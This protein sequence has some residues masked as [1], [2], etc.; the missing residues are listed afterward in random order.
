ML[1]VKKQPYNSVWI[2]ADS[3]EELGLT[4][5]RF[6]EYYE[7]ANLTF[8]NKIFTLGQLRY[9]YSEKYGANDYHLTWIGFNFPSRVLTPF[10]EGL[11]DPL[12][13]EE[14][15]LLE[16]LRYRKDE[17]Y[18]IGA[19]NHNVLRHE[20]AHALYASNPKYKLEIDNFLGKH[21]SKLIKTNKY[22]LNKGYSKDVLNDEIQA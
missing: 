8:R 9:W 19:Q 18:I 17:F 20:L 2:S 7:S 1:K 4:F 14:N 3:Q 13:P 10:K 6:Q 5:M 16:L 15:R 22:I 11:F 12:T 21:K